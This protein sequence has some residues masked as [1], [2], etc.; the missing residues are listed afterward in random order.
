MIDDINKRLG[1]MPQ[2]VRMLI[3][4]IEEKDVKTP[5]NNMLYSEDVIPLKEGPNSAK[6]FHTEGY[7]GKDFSVFDA[8]VREDYRVRKQS[9]GKIKMFE[10]GIP[11]D[12]LNRFYEEIR[13]FCERGDA[14]CEEAK[15][16]YA[17]VGEHERF[18]RDIRKSYQDY[19]RARIIQE[20]ILEN[21]REDEPRVQFFIN[22]RT[23][24]AMIM[25]GEADIVFR[26]SKVTCNYDYTIRFVDRALDMLEY[27]TDEV[28]EMSENIIIGNM[29]EIGEEFGR[30]VQTL[31]AMKHDAES[32]D[33]IALYGD[34]QSA[35]SLPSP[36]EIPLDMRSG[37]L[38]ANEK[39]RDAAKAK[40]MF[41]MRRRLD[42]LYLKS[43]MPVPF[44]DDFL[45]TNPGK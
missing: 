20:Y 34:S 13:T 5:T 25:T 31:Q 41:E 28:Q 38:A 8:L 7:P 35:T 10:K 17:Q 22:H 42:P 2:K 45:V 19:E 23:N 30:Y 33:W 26:T 16:I 32:L 11:V 9:G 4:N 1:F 14:F 39:Y 36:K 40:K 6:L 27:L 15:G 29:M 12:L 43:E 21:E 18:F 44:L 3:E 37:M 24:L